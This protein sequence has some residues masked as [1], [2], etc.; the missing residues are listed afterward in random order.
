MILYHGS[1]LIVDPPIWGKGK[2]TNDYGRG[3]YC[4]QDLELAKEWACSRA[5]DGFA[6]IYEFDTSG[7]AILDLNSHLVGNSRALSLLLGKRQYFRPSE[8]VSGE[9]FFRVS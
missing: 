6:N 3:F 4:T 5:M 8:K 2:T 1:S 7:L 9:A